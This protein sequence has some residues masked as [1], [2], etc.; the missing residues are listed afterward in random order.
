M[1]PNTSSGPRNVC[2]QVK[3]RSSTFVV[4]HRRIQLSLGIL[5]KDGGLHFS[6]NRRAA[7]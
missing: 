7:A 4:R 2:L 1:M 5:V 3:A 6:G